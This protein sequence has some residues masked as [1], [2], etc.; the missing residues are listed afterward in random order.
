MARKIDTIIIHCSATEYGNVSLFRKWHKSFGWDDIGYHY[1]I[2]NSYPTKISWSSKKPIYKKD[3]NLQ[4]GRDI[5]VVGAHTKGYNSGSIGIC[6]VGDRTFTGRQFLNL[7]ELVK[8]LTSV[9]KIK[10]IKGH[11]EY[12]TAKVQGK[13]C[14]NIDMD[15]LRNELKISE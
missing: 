7:K 4:I 3:G 12:D 15:W 5:D 8:T 1:V 2:N 13:T 11:Y 6:L 9:Y 10:H 14:P